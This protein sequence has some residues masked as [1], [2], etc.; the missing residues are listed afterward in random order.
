MVQTVSMAASLGTIGERAPAKAGIRQLARAMALSAHSAVLE[1]RPSMTTYDLELKRLEREMFRLRMWLN[2]ERFGGHSDVERM[3]V[4]K[5][6][7]NK[8]GHRY[9]KTY[10]QNR[11]RLT[12]Y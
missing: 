5:R 10:V 8:V 11:M 3:R 4:L 12:A 2:E 6:M 1:R 7:L 9:A